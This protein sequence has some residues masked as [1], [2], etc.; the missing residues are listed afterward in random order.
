MK[1]VAQGHGFVYALGGEKVEGFTSLLW[2][3]IG[4][5]IYSL[6]LH[7]EHTLLAINIL[8]IS[9]VISRLWKY[10]NEAD[11]SQSII[12]PQT[13]ILL[14]IIATAPGFI[15]WNVLSLLETGLWTTLLSH[16][17]L[18]I[19]E[20]KHQ[21][22]GLLL[23]A[24]L[25]LCRP[26][27]I[28][29]GLA[30]A[31]IPM[32]IRYINKTSFKATYALPLLI[33]IGTMITLVSWRLSYFGYPLP[34]T[35][36]AKV[37]SDILGNAFAGLKYD[38]KFLIG[39]PIMILILG[40]MMYHA[41]SLFKKHYA[42]STTTIARS[43]VLIVVGCIS[44]L[45]PI[46]S[47]GDHFNSFRFFQS[48]LPLIVLYFVLFPSKS[49][50]G[51]S[52]VHAVLF[53]IFSMIGSQWLIYAVKGETPLKHE[54]T[55]ALE[56][57]TQSEDLQ[58]FFANSTLPTQGVL[59]AGG[60]AYA[61]QGITIDLLGLNNTRMAHADKVK[62]KGLMKNHASF[63]KDVFYELKP[64]IFWMG[65]GFSSI[66]QSTLNLP[67]FNAMIF[68]NIHND[69]RFKKEYG[70]FELRNNQGRYLHVL[71]N[72]QFIEGLDTS[73]FS[74]KEIAYH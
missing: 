1:H 25:I 45:I 9:S 57:R 54:W 69:V 51:I 34:N 64:D 5:G 65:G 46:Y 15:E 74:I 29:W 41:A 31:V 63:N 18:N 66:Q 72:R 7:L 21:K 20:D 17:T 70:A 22:W 24:L 37:S 58:I 19:I 53:T 40:L 44:F 32:I 13:L 59:V 50:Q 36:Y 67:T 4:S 62:S 60:T 26:E 14:G 6:G 12:H 10:C 49:V 43:I 71:C 68:K 8:L 56:G 42:D 39:F 16:I 11:K 30:L 2:T 47:G 3:L 33:V 73:K 52:Y 35:Y 27:A 55:I 48:T 61:Y 23:F 38:A 28:L